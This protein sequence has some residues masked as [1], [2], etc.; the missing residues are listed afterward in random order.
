LGQKENEDQEDQMVTE[1]KKDLAVR[2]EKKER[3]EKED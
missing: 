2:K 1:V 3:M